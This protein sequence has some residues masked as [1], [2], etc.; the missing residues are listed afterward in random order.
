MIKEKKKSDI[1]IQIIIFYKSIFP[2]V[3]KIDKEALKEKE[4]KRRRR[5]KRN[6]NLYN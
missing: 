6:N 4:K 3:K 1:I 5:I 2:E